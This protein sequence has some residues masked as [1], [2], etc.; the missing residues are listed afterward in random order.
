MKPLVEYE[1]CLRDS[2]KFRAV[3]EEQEADIEQLEQKLEKVVKT[4]SSMIDVGKNFVS[5]QSQFTNSL[6]DLSTYFKDDI[7][8]MASLNKL[9]HSLQEMS[10]FQTI[11]LDQ[12][13][14]TVLKNLNS[15]VKNDIKQTK[16]SKHHF[17]KI[18]ADLDAALL[19][20][21]QASR[22]KTTEAE[23]ALNILSAT[24]LCFRHTALDYLH[25]LSHLQA[26]KRHEVIGT[27]LSYMHA[28]NTFFHQGS[29]LC[30]DLEPFFKKLAN[31]LVK[32]RGDSG[33]L[34]RDTEVRHAAVTGKDIVPDISNGEL[35]EGKSLCMEGYLFKRTSNAFKTWNRRWFSLQDNQLVY[36]K[37]S[38]F[39]Q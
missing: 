15:F 16:E 7:E 11:L 18:S 25:S 13:S 39:A 24:R 26:R 30:Q 32:M 9:I 3:L 31:D 20:N 28:C 27:L 14:R 6:W 37:R 5:H 19:R 34:D 33:D 36:R 21:S 1:E 10:K 29:D 12:A 38:G 23:E 35:P 2:P 17:E 22:T 8:V 4:C